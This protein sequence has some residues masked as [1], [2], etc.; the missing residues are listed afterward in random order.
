MRSAA[1]VV[2]VLKRCKDDLTRKN[3]MRQ[4]ASL[5]DVPS[6]VFIPGILVNTSA[7]NFAP[8]QQSQAHAFKGER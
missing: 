2:Q 4:A 7:T 5:R 6:D 8:I 1:Q 3:I